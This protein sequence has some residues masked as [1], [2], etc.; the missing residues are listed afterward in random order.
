MP[1]YGGAQLFFKN[2]KK[3]NIHLFEDNSFSD[4]Q[5]IFENPIKSIEVIEVSEVPLE[6]MLIV[7]DSQNAIDKENE[8]EFPERKNDFT[9]N[10]VSIHCIKT[11]IQF[12]N[13]CF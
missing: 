1:H 12:S 13:Y 9:I 2:G 5:N 8:S 10:I 6:T 4:N 7:E 3:R 11:G